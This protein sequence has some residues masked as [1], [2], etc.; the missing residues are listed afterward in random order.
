MLGSLVVLS[1]AYSP[2]T[3]PEAGD[4]EQHCRRVECK[5]VA[6]LPCLTL[7]GVRFH[8]LP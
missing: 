1:A 3:Q 6:N 5:F 4:L 2:D 8:I 7:C